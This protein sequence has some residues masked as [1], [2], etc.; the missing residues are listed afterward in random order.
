[1]DSDT[2]SSKKTRVAHPAGDLLQDYLDNLLMT[3]TLTGAPK[4]TAPKETAPKP[5]RGNQ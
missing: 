3:A 2:G 5:S 1:M 4:E